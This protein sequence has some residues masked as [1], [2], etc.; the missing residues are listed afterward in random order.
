MSNVNCTQ[1]LSA[2]LKSN[3]RVCA[4][5]CVSVSDSA[6][7]HTQTLERNDETETRDALQLLIPSDEA[8]SSSDTIHLPWLNLNLPGCSMSNSLRTAGIRQATSNCFSFR[9]S[10]VTKA[11]QRFSQSSSKRSAVASLLRTR[12]LWGAWLSTVVRKLADVDMWLQILI[13]GCARFLLRLLG[14][15]KLAS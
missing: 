14:N 15:C 2:Q 10:T 5:V 4:R 6:A 12:P 13:Q 7:A 11:V 8:D 9:F 1:D 3:P